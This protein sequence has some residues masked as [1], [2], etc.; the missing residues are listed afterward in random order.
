M[1]AKRSIDFSS[2]ELPEGSR[3]VI[4]P[5]ASLETTPIDSLK[6]NNTPPGLPRFLRDTR[7]VLGPIRAINRLERFFFF[8]L[9]FGTL[10]QGCNLEPYAF[11][12]DLE[13]NEYRSLPAYHLRAVGRTELL[14]KKI[15]I[16]VAAVR[17]T[18]PCVL[19]IR[20]IGSRDRGQNQE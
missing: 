20:A 5:A 7:D 10:A 19:A 12:S 2:G 15:L 13:S 6:D 18:V 4:S 14:Y 16:K 1:L 17:L 11:A 9:A 8:V 3:Q